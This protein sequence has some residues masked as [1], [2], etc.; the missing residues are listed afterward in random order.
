MWSESPHRL[1]QV[2]EPVQ[3]VSR[4]RASQRQQAIRPLTIRFDR[5][6]QTDPEDI[7]CDPSSAPN[8]P[9]SFLGPPLVPET[10]PE[11]SQ[12]IER[13]IFCSSAALLFPSRIRSVISRPSVA[14]SFPRWRHRGNVKKA[15]GPR[16]PVFWRAKDQVRN[17]DN[18]YAIS[19]TAPYMGKK[20]KQRSK[21]LQKRMPTSK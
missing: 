20:E 15:V 9:Q 1:S 3:L 11:S 12:S 6:V 5:A 13:A 7:A 4:A 16:R 8:L 14:I 19:S 17:D 18:G 10:F 21:K 2:V